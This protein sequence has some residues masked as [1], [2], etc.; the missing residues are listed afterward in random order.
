MIIIMSYRIL[1][2]AILLG[3]LRIIMDVLD[4]LILMVKVAVAQL[5]DAK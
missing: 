1:V 4:C 3:L 2:S 5:I